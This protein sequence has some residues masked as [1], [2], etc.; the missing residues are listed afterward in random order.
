MNLLK[1]LI[2][3]KNIEIV[4]N[5]TRLKIG[6]INRISN[7]FDLLFDYC[8]FKIDRF[9]IKIYITIFYWFKKFQPDGKRIALFSYKYNPGTKIESIEH[10]SIEPT[11]IHFCNSNKFD[12]VTVNYWDVDRELLLFSVGFFKKIIKANFSCIVLSSYS[13]SKYYQPDIWLLEKMVQMGITIK[14]I[15]WDTCSNSFSETINRELSIGSQHILIENPSLHFIQNKK[16]VLHK[17]TPLY[18]PLPLQDFN[19]KKNIDVAFMGQISDYR[20]SRKKYLEYL[21]NNNVSLYYSARNKAEQFSYKDYLAVL[22]KSKIGINFSMSVDCHQLKARV[23]ET[24]L[25]GSLLLEQKNEQIEHYFK[26]G[27]DYV[28]FESESDLLDKINYYLKNNDLRIKIAESGRDAVL[29]NYSGDK[30][31]T[32]ILVI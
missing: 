4:G 8:L 17:I 14:F 19:I 32:A 3:K 28:S 6:L 7:L 27:I 26:D 13:S 16:G 25:A 23:F 12:G 22:R 30:F 24:M 5:P 9:S 29:N 21:L 20:D 15:W 2:S 18:T 1:S 10:H 31:W 11:L